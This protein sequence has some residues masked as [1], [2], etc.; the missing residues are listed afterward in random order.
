MRNFIENGIERQNRARNANHAKWCF[1]YSC[2]RCC[3]MGLQ[4]KCKGCAIK[5]A[6]KKALERFG[7]HYIEEED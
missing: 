2:E 6:H 7:E 4:I 1:G 5:G 3:I